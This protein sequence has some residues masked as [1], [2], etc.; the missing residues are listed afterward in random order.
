[1]EVKDLRIKVTNEMLAS[2]KV[3][4]LY[5]W[6]NSFN[7]KITGIR[8]D[9]I[10]HL[11]RYGN[12]NKG[13]G[14][15]LCK[16][17]SL[18]LSLSLVFELRRFLSLVCLGPMACCRLLAHEPTCRLPSRIAHGGTAA[19]TS[20]ISMLRAPPLAGFSLSLSPPIAAL[21]LCPLAAALAALAAAPPSHPALDHQHAVECH[22]DARRA[23]HVC[24]V[25]SAR[26]V[27]FLLV[28][29]L[30][31]SYCGTRERAE[32]NGP[33]PLT[34]PAAHRVLFEEMCPTQNTYTSQFL[35][36]FLCWLVG[37]L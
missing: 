21:R 35:Y 7:K 26:S 32:S 2:M 5:A 13:N 24:L 11:R 33:A 22:A 10:N 3:I 28:V 37:W 8:N 25:R 15:L 20:S 6:E 9:E 29:V 27:S 14:R 12:K 31:C 30:V 16:K 19:V 1:M 17:V 18:S 23:D 34:T 4:K 36:V